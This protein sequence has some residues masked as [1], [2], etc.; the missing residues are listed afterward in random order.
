M[1]AARFFQAAAELAL[2]KHHNCQ[3]EAIFDDAPWAPE[4]TYSAQLVILR[5]ALARE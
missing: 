3:G 4:A 2:C 5:A 1:P